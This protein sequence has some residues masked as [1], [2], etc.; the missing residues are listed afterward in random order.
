MVDYGV[1]RQ[2]VVFSAQMLLWRIYT[3]VCMV[4]C[5]QHF[6]FSTHLQGSLNDRFLIS[7]VVMHESYISVLSFIKQYPNLSLAPGGIE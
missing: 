5:K 6:A 1:C 3:Y 7:S 2:L 4:M